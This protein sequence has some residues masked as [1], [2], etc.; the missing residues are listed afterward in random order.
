MGAA[1]NSLAN[2]FKVLP[3]FIG[4]YLEA[5]QAQ[6]LEHSPEAA[7]SGQP[8]YAQEWDT[9]MIPP[10]TMA[11]SDERG[12]FYMINA[13]KDGISLFGSLYGGQYEIIEES[14]LSAMQ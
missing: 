1:V 5:L 2:Q 9:I 8:L 6:I 12:Q 4:D 11:T 14:Y 13:S 10:P 3:V 7:A